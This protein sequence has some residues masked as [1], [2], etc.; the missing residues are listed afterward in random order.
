MLKTYF[1]LFLCFQANATENERAHDT[2]E[3]VDAPDPNTVVTMLPEGNQPDPSVKEIIPIILCQESIS[4]G[5]VARAIETVC[6]YW[7]PKRPTPPSSCSS[8]DECDEEVS[9]PP[10]NI[11]PTQKAVIIFDASKSPSNPLRH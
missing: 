9:S 10:Q 6:A 8:L 7:N 11:A 4:P 1:F 3:I 2:W 5:I